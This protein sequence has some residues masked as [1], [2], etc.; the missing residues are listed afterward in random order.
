MSIASKNL[1]IAASLGI[2][3]NMTRE[4]GCKTKKMP[5]AIATPFFNLQLSTYSK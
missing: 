5:H 2:E 3:L 4:N 1:H